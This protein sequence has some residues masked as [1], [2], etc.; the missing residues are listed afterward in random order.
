M[1]LCLMASCFTPSW[2]WSSSIEING[3]SYGKHLCSSLSLPCSHHAL[4]WVTLIRFLCSNRGCF[5]FPGNSRFWQSLVVSFLS[6]LPSLQSRDHTIPLGPHCVMGDSCR[7]PVPLCSFPALNHRFAL[8]L[9]H[10]ARFNFGAIQRLR[11]AGGQEGQNHTPHGDS[12]CPVTAFQ[13]SQ[14]VQLSE[15]CSH[16]AQ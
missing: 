9:P 3:L 14:E 16:L 12:N 5:W 7:C 10:H 1:Y 11:W 4:V 13:L 6:S 15:L 8:P 2:Y